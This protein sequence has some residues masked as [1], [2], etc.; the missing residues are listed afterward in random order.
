MTHSVER[1]AVHL[2][3][4]QNVY[5]REGQEERALEINQNTTLTA[6]FHLNNRDPEA[7]EHLYHEIPEHYTFNNRTKTWKKR[8]RPAK[9]Y[10]CMYQVL[11]SQPEKFSLR[12][13]LLHC[14]GAL[15]FQD[16]R[17]VEDHECPTFQDAA[18]AMGLLQDDTEL[19]RC[20]EEA[21]V[22][23]MPRQMRALFATILLFNPPSDPHQLF[24][25]FQEAMSEDF[26]NAERHRQ[27]NDAVVFE[28]RHMHLCL[29]NIDMKLKSHGKSI[30]DEEFRPF[31]S[32]LLTST[33]QVKRCW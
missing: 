14:P 18:R 3:L 1:L 23:Q 27:N 8:Q 11:P 33:L 22:M 20:L 29:F 32:Y 7:R 16:L 10:S 31:H 12:T 21:R 15:S 13:L 24:L 2:P 30:R 6:W 28:Q 19:R 26:V 5:F 4:Q 9:I 25:D 17:T